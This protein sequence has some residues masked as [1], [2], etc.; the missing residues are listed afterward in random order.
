LFPYRTLFR[1][2]FDVGGRVERSLIPGFLGLFVKL[3]E[4]V[5][6]GAG[7]GEVRHLGPAIRVAGDLLMALRSEE[8]IHVVER[9]VKPYDDPP[10]QMLGGDL[11][12]EGLEP[13]SREK[14]LATS[15]HEPGQ[16][17][18]P[19]RTAAPEGR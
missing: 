15:R 7:L 6:D 10:L 8:G 16:R 9:D 5:P 3:F 14:V 12:G 4:L 2:R 11:G 1:S 19:G 18:R 13:V 17:S